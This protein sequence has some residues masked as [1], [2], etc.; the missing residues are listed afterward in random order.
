MSPPFT[1]ISIT[2]LDKAATEQSPTAS[3]LRLMHLTLSDFPPHVWTQLFDAEREFA[4]HSKWRH[5]RIQGALIVVDCVPE[6]LPEH[7]RDLKEDVA[8]SN[9][10]FRGY[11]AQEERR[12][13]AAEEAAKL[14]RERI[15]QISKGLDFA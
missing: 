3:G 14:E 12:S 6:E 2:G 15:E 7:L 8:N 9:N 4:R 10:K 11:L 13:I 5:A 1:D